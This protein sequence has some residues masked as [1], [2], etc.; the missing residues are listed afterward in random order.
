[1]TAPN[2]RTTPRP[3]GRTKY[4][5]ERC[6]CE[7]CRAEA[8]RYEQHRNR[9]RAYGRVAYVDAEPARTHVRE[10]MAAGLGWKRVAAVAGVPN[11][12]M[13][14]LLYGHPQRGSMP[15]QR[16]R[17]ATAEKVLAISADAVG[18][19]DH[20]LVDAL[21]C[22]RRL[23]A[24]VACGWSQCKLAEAIGVSRPN[25]GAMMRS[26]QVHASTARTVRALYERLWD[27]RPP[28]ATHREKISVSR[29][30]CYARERG[31]VVPMAWDDIDDPDETPDVGEQDRRGGV[32]MDEVRWLRS[33]GTSDELIAK[34]LGTTI[35]SIYR[36][37]ERER[38]A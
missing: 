1:M 26:A 23:Q 17:L 30:K 8:R 34:R 37:M 28:Q 5:V 38:A 27:Q 18:L 36:A 33:F 29:A 25:F 12:T 20:A 19:A 32:D 14:K 10:L 9:Q 31:W 21:G 7:T 11:G 4:V 35:R 13:T 16:I 3:H 22:H 15:S 6:R 24:L 2:A